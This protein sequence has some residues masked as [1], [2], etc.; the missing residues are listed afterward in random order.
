MTNKIQ[1]LTSLQHPFVK[2]LVKLREDREYRYQS[3]SVVVCGLKLVQELSILF[4]FQSLILEEGFNP[5]F[6]I[7]RAQEGFVNLDSA[8]QSTI[9][10]RGPND[11]AIVKTMAEEE[12][13]LGKATAS[14][15]SLNLTER[16]IQTENLYHVTPQVMKKISGLQQPEPIA[17]EVRMP[18][19]QDLSSLQFLLVL[20]KISD[21][22]NLGTLLRSARGLGWDGVFLTPGSTDPFNDKAIRA[23]KGATFTLPW[24]SGTYE[25]LDAL[26]MKRKLYAADAKGADFS[27]LQFAPPLALALGSES[28]GLAEELKKN[29]EMISIPMHGKV[30]SLNVGSAGA[31][32]MYQLRQR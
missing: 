6:K 2:H 23:A 11:E 8:R 25:E 30:E 21:P 9:E 16:G 31:I 28:H 12:D 18:K 32:L 5:V 22:G 17:A 19:P 10:A 3:Q 27:T 13:R 14:P 4:P 24:R 1:Q 29:A 20:D 26:L 15:N 7:Y